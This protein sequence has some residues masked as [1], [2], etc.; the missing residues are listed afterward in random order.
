[1]RLLVLLLLAASLAAGEP[2]F[3][4]LKEAKTAVV[5][6]RDAAFEQI[7]KE[8]LLIPD[9]FVDAERCYQEAMRAWWDKRWND[10]LA[11]FERSFDLYSQSAARAK[12]Q[13]A[14]LPAENQA[15]GIRS[16][17]QRAIDA[18][19]AWL[20]AHQDPV[21]Y[22]DCD[23]FMKHDP[24]DDRCDGPGYAPNNIGVTALATLAF[25]EAGAS[26]RR[27]EVYRAIQW[28]RYQQTEEGTIGKRP[29]FHFIYGHAIATLVLA[30]AYQRSKDARYL[31]QLKPALDYILKAQTPGKGWRY[32][33]KDADA[34]TSITVWCY[35][36]LAAGVE[37]GIELD[38]AEAAKG[39]RA[40]L[41]SM[42]AE[43]GQVGYDW[44]GLVARPDPRKRQFPE[45][46]SRA[47]TA[48]GV[49]LRVLLDGDKVD[50]KRLQKGLDQCLRRPPS[51]NPDDG[52]IDMYY[53]Y[54][55]TLACAADKTH[56]RK[57]K[58]PLLDA[59]LK[60]QHPSG[61]GA[62]TGS[63]DPIGAW[64]DDGGRVYSTAILAL[65]LAHAE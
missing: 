36:A 39:T 13:I 54:Y 34:D 6:A 20:S 46:R 26:D 11:A 42:T 65:A 55:G 32:D 60:H 41:D 59:L 40:W 4:D 38:L 35:R 5:N 43:D 7:K 15:A 37:A 19:L 44:P 49:V 50:K 56:A 31:E 2:R 9:A 14:S 61:S 47:M 1:M 53:W 52:S 48:A 63:W 64:G 57:W 23:E 28:L 58:K 3:K 24:A 45:D 18:A 17:Q 27:P 21:G 25:L 22:W 10:A 51:W 8:G 16:P 62:R 33:P 29:P 30:K 12:E